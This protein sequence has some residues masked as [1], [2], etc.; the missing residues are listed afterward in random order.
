MLNLSFPFFILFI[1][2][3]GPDPAITDGEKPWVGIIV[4][5]MGIAFVGCALWVLHTQS[6]ETSKDDGFYNYTRGYN[7]QVFWM[8]I[9]LSAFGVLYLLVA[10]DIL[11][12]T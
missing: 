3:F 7:W 4:L 6:P 9:A 11:R 10:Y 12:V 1:P 8:G 2:P 5:L